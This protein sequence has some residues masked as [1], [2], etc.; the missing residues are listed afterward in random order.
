MPNKNPN[1]W[2]TLIVVL[3]EYGFVMCITFLLSYLRII[4]DQKEHSLARRLLESTIGSLLA[5]I[6]GLAFEKLGWSEG[7]TYGAAGF[8][9]VFGISQIR[10]WGR[11]WAESKIKDRPQFNDYRKKDR[12]KKEDDEL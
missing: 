2:E 12:Y 4:Y 9:S 11:K 6:A 10:A 7:W 1:F 5:L 8:I 3:S